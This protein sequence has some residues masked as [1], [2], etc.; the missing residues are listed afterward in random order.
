MT[1][2][3]GDA[4]LTWGLV[5]RSSHLCDQAMCLHVQYW[6]KSTLRWQGEVQVLRS[7]IYIQCRVE[8]VLLRANNSKKYKVCLSPALCTERKELVKCVSSVLCPFHFQTDADSFL[9]AIMPAKGKGMVC[10][11]LKAAQ[12][13]RYLKCS[14]LR[15]RESEYN[16]WFYFTHLS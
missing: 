12:H 3:C 14:L 16:K 13:H 4:A 15:K 2:V 6:I 11:F 9:A 7:I 5:T 8:C 1:F 10:I